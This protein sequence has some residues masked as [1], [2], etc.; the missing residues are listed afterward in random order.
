MINKTKFFMDATLNI[1]STL[2]IETA[3]W[4]C[5]FY[6][7]DFLPATHM[8]FHV[9]DYE[10]GITETIAMADM[11]GGQT[12]SLKNLHDIDVRNDIKE[13]WVQGVHC[14]DRIGDLSFLRATAREFGL[15]E[16]S[17]MIMD[18]MLE[19]EE[20]GVVSIL[21]EKGTPFSDE[22]TDLFKLLNKPFGIAITNALRYRELKCLKDVLADDNRYLQNEL[23]GSVGKEIVG[24]D[25][26]LKGVMDQVYQVAGHDS[27][28]LILGETGTG[29]EVIAN[30][31]HHLSSRKNGPFIKIN[32]GAIPATLIDSELFGH[33]KNAFTGANTMKRGRF[34]R[35]DGGTIFLDEIGELSLDAQVRLLRVLQEKELERVGGTEPVKVNTRVIAATHRDLDDM[36]KKGRFRKDLYFRIK[37]FPIMIPPLRERI[38]DIPMLVQYLVQKKARE[39]NKPIVSRMA[40]DSVDRL[41][42]YD[43]PGNI[44]ELENVVERALIK[45]QG[46]PLDFDLGPT[47][48][49]RKECSL[50]YPPDAQMLNLDQ[51]NAAHIKRVL[52]LAKGKIDGHGGA[53]QLLGINPN[54]L[55]HRMK[56][57]GV[58]YGRRNKRQNS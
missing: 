55:R 43:W 25:T 5:L 11:S 9:Y 32:C 35:A 14:F 57:L 39:L 51:V 44:R 26:G 28:V 18:L 52:G 20:V 30:A 42:A 46:E 12:V 58:P 37:V 33:E 54:T 6:L 31:I 3:L 1:C 10:L 50:A 22:H 7:K 56:K 36:L 47:G 19:N 13:N 8:G 48:K 17:A 45:N 2:D 21:D 15:S 24:A 41:M 16:A 23:T 38:T 49:T 53:A 29:K 34:E 27:P 40:V 4:N